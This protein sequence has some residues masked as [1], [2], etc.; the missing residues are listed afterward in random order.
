MFL[1]NFFHE[2][3]FIY[4][5]CARTS[6]SLQPVGLYPL[7]NTIAGYSLCYDNVG[8]T[9]VPRHQGFSRKKDVRTMTSSFA[10]RDRVMVETTDKPL[11]ACSE[12][13]ARVILPNTSDHVSRRERMV[14]IV[15]RILAAHM[16]DFQ[17]C[18]V[19]EHVRHTFS[20]EMSRSS[21]T[22]SFGMLDCNPGSSEG[23]VKVN[24]KIM[25]TIF[26]TER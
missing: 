11:V 13:N 17:R 4:Q 10:V 20:D 1:Q 3:I 22:L 14:V 9:V 19:V 24:I 5:Y 2:P 21:E 26:L 6:I 25:C 23:G 7:K 18:P 8:F 16:P 15:G 12:M